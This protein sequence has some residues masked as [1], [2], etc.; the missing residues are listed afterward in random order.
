[1]DSM[2]LS[3]SKAKNHAFPHL[4]TDGSVLGLSPCCG[5]RRS[6]LACD[7]LH[8]ITSIP[9]SSIYSSKIKDKLAQKII[10]LSGKSLFHSLLIPLVAT[11]A[12]VMKTSSNWLREIWWIKSNHCGIQKFTSMA[13]NNRRKILKVRFNV[14]LRG[15]DGERTDNL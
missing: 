7:R 3:S 9:H 15:K 10:C 2:L 14:S 4:H 5:G 8:V 12:A 1:M 11:E 13:F 6:Y